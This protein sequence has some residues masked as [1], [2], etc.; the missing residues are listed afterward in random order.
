MHPAPVNDEIVR[1][2]GVAGRICGLLQ[3][4]AST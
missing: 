3:A 1:A 4:I 2:D